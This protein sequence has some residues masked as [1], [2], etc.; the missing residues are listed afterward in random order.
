VAGT[1]NSALNERNRRICLLRRNGLTYGEIATMEQISRPRVAQI[2]AETMPE[3]G[4]DEGRAELSGILEFVERK[5]VGLINDPGP[6]M[7]PAGTPAR[8]TDGNQVP[9]N[10]IVV[11]GLKIL[12]LVSEKKARL[13][14]WDKQPKKDPREHFEQS[15][16][17]MLE[18][19]AAERLRMDERRLAAAE[20]AEL[21][22]YRS[23]SALPPV[24][25][26]EVLRPEK[27]RGEEG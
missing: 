20:R 9:N 5:A 27:Q 8:D 14:A 19:L 21:E 15:H 18:A 6:L 23:R 11:E 13:F 16:A 25:Q 4:E 26:G 22:A 17:A 2:V 3:L 12:T 7:G 24:V 1:K 10:G